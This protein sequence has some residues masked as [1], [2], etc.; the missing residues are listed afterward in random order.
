M[1]FDAQV[2]HERFASRDD[3]Y[4]STTLCKRI[5]WQHSANG[6]IIVDREDQT[7][8]TGFIVGRVSPWNLKCGTTGNYLKKGG[9]EKAKYQLHLMRPTDKILGRDFDAAITNLETMQK[10]AGTTGDHRNMVIRD[11]T[12]EMLRVTANVFEQRPARIPDSPDGK[13]APDAPKMDSITESW[14]IPTDL[15]D[16]FE[17]VKYTHRAVPLP[18][19]EDGQAIPPL[20]ANRTLD[21]ALVEVHFTVLQWHVQGYDTFLAKAGRINILKRSVSVASKHPLSDVDDEQPVHKKH[22]TAIASGSKD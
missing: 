4:A 18:V 1:S 15:E 12:G 20:D 2:Y 17:L 5:S 10:V 13:R 21:G 16:Q 9:L 19:F 11:V 7:P 8:F 3:S 22:E 6:L 14:V